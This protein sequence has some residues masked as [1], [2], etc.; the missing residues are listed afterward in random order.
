M[1]LLLLLTWIVAYLN[2]PRFFIQ[3][4]LQKNWE[5]VGLERNANFDIVG[6]KDEQYSSKNYGSDSLFL[7]FFKF[8]P[9]GAFQAKLNEKYQQCLSKVVRSVT[10]NLMINSVGG[11]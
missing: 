11:K 8:P 6:N 2:N 1:L 10:F 5:V 7:F 9:L 3:N 4:H